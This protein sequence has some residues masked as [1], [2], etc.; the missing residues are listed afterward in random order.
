MASA[1]SGL[2]HPASA[3]CLGRHSRL[4]GRCPNNSSLFP[5]L[6]AVVVVALWASRAERIFCIAVPKRLRAFRNCFFMGEIAVESLS[7]A[8]SF[9]T[10]FCVPKGCARAFLGFFRAIRCI[11]GAIHAELLHFC[12]R[13]WYTTGT[14]QYSVQYAI[15]IIP[16]E[17]K[18]V[19]Q[20]QA[21]RFSVFCGCARRA[22]SFQRICGAIHVQN[23][24]K[25]AKRGTLG[26]TKS[27]RLGRALE[28]ERILC[29]NG[30]SAWFW[31]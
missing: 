16:I 15:P 11:S 4:A 10:L 19:R 1:A 30:S 24:P 8:H 14:E 12:R 6:A 21:G 27:A 31:R 18:T 7:G 29:K 22:G 3:S 13:S 5:P 28:K 23:R 26:T 9:A 2:R 17:Q 20:P 25:R